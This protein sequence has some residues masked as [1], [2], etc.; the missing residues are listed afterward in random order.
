MRLTDRMC[1]GVIR[2]VFGDD[3]EMLMDS[4]L[5]A[6]DEHLEEESS[7]TPPPRACRAHAD[8]QGGRFQARATAPS[9]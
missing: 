4:F 2:T 6:L 7:P 5:G 1:M 9:T 8:T 3:P